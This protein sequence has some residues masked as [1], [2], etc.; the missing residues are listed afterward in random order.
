MGVEE[1]EDAHLVGADSQLMLLAAFSQDGADIRTALVGLPGEEPARVLV[2]VEFVEAAHAELDLLRQDHHESV[3]FG[4]I[5]PVPCG[6]DLHIHIEGELLGEL[7]GA[8]LVHG[9][10]RH[11]DVLEH[12]L[13][14]LGELEPALLLQLLDQQL[15][16]IFVGRPLL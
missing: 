3:I 6:Q 9:L 13:Q 4:V 12:H 16:R 7:G 10:V 8:E 2:R 1:H 11:L 15:L 5:G 14:L